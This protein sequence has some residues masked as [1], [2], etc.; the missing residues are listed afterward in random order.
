MQGVIETS[1]KEYEGRVAYF[2]SIRS[3]WRLSA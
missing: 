2:D 3:I 1:K